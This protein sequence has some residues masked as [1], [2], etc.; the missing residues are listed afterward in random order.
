MSHAWASCFRAFLL[1][2]LAPRYSAA[3]ESQRRVT[4]S[5]LS[6]LLSRHWYPPR[7][8]RQEVRI[9]ILGLDNAGKTTILNKL[10]SPDKVIV[11][12]DELLYFFR[13]YCERLYFIPS[14]TCLSACP[15]VTAAAESA[16]HSHD[17]NNRVQRGKGRAQEY[18]FRF[19]GLGR[20][21]QYQVRGPRLDSLAFA[22]HSTS[23]RS[24]HSILDNVDTSS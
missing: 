4:L 24:L 9:L 19:M 8:S 16:D 17:T 20:T 13:S 22:F 6:W 12:L 1:D 21:I 23:L 5:A 18:Q 15:M 3:L 14:F 11:R 2:F 10:H 7:F